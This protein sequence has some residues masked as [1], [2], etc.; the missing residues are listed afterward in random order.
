MTRAKQ[1][2]IGRVDPNTS[3]MDLGAVEQC[4]ST[5]IIGLHLL[6]HTKQ[7]LIA[8]LQQLHTCPADPK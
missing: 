1:K 8:Y 6:I 4:R 2:L 7:P 5:V 3:S